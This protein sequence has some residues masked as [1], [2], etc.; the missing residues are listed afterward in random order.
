MSG[1]WFDAP[2]NPF[3]QMNYTR[4]GGGYNNRDTAHSNARRA[5]A[6]EGAGASA[7]PHFRDTKTAQAALVG[8]QLAVVGGDTVVRT[9]GSGA[10]GASTK[11]GSGGS[12][13]G[14]A[15]AAAGSGGRGAGSKLALSA[16]PLTMAAKDSGTEIFTG[17]DWWKSNP[18]WSDTEEWEARYGEPGDWLG[19]VVVAG[20]DTFFNVARGI[21]HVTGSRMVTERT[22][23]PQVQYGDGMSTVL[24]VLDNLGGAFAR[25]DA[26]WSQQL[27]R[28]F[29]TGKVVPMGG[30]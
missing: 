23:V 4:G 10:T 9:T 17:G 1:S 3:N 12:G 28:Q 24:G 21:D 13:P 25:Q 5:H 19:G 16:P 18:W 2:E 30:F 14:S 29:N 11:G 7:L 20:A 26:Q 8:R 27:N 6:M 15:G 22:D